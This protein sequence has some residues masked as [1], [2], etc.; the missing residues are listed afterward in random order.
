LFKSDTV[1]PFIS[2]SKVN[3]AIWKIGPI[4]SPPNRLAE[5]KRSFTRSQ[6]ARRL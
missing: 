1:N 5:R 4:N 2:I 3:Q 6:R